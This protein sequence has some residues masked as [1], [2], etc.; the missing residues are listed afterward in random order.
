MIKYVHPDV[1]RIDYPRIINDMDE[2]QIKQF[3]DCY[4]KAVQEI[5]ENLY[6]QGS[7]LDYDLRGWNKKKFFSEKLPPAKKKPDM[8]IIYRYD[9]E[10]NNLY[11]LAVGKRE[12]KEVDSVYRFAKNRNKDDWDWNNPMAYRPWANPELRAIEDRVFRLRERW[13]RW[14]KWFNRG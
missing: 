11:I 4:L 13:Q 14:R 9:N 10:H 7:A 5:M 8:R 3:V 12:A 6:Q 2:E 1:K